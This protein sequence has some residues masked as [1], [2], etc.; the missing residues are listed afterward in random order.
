MNFLIECCWP[1]DT[2]LVFWYATDCLAGQPDVTEEE[3][4]EHVATELWPHASCDQELAIWVA[5]ASYC[6]QKP[7][8]L[9]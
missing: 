3:L 1:V 7:H 9:I 4:C 5:V 8:S 2:D 6:W